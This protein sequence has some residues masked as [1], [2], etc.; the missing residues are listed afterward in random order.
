[1]IILQPTRSLLSSCDQLALE[2]QIAADKSY[3]IDPNNPAG[4]LIN[5]RVGPPATFSRASGATEVDSAGRIVFSNENF[6]LYSNEIILNR[7]WALG[8]TTSTL[9]GTAP[10]GGNAYLITETT[11]NALHNC[12]S[13]GST[14]NIGA[15]TTMLGMIYTGSLFVKKVEGSIDWIQITMGSGGFGTAQYANFNIANGTVGN[16]ANLAP[17]TTPTIEAYG[18][19]WYR[20]SIAAVE[21]ANTTNS[22][23]FSLGF[24]N[25]INGTV[26]LPVYAGNPANRVF[27]AMGQFQ[28]NSFTGPYILTTT[29]PRFAPSFYHDPA[30][31]QSRGLYT[32][33]GRTN[34]VRQ[35]EAF[36][37]TWTRSAI[38]ISSNV[39]I[40]PSG[41]R[42]A[43]RLIE[44]ASTAAHGIAQNIT[45]TATP[46]T[47]SLYAKA[48][49]RNWIRL[50]FGNP[51]PDNVWFNLANGTIGTISTGFSA[52]MQNAGNGWWRCIITRTPTAGLLST[53]MR[54]AS[55][56]GN[57]S[58]PGN[59]SG[60]VYLW[61]AQVEPGPF[62]TRYNPTTNANTIRSVDVCDINGAGFAEMYNPLEG[63]LCVSAIF[64]API[65]YSTSQML[66]DINDTTVSN[67]LRIF[68][69][70]ST[71]Y[72]GFNNTSNSITNVSITTSVAAQP[73]EIQK[74]SV[75]FKQNDYAFYANN[76]LIGTDTD[77]AMPISPTTLT[78]G[79]AA[80]GFSRLYTNGIISSIRY[81]RRRLPNP[82]LL[83][84][85][86]P[87]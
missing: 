61:G 9:S 34:I 49:T 86:Q 65:N 78:I 85:T 33:E 25:N 79:D 23:A 57:I 18:D 28:R 46:H 62:V 74:Y 36:E 75:G 19:G 2:L 30:S 59:G 45:Y 13:Y 42:T 29:S 11:D 32:E 6:A 73:F 71:G 4:F 3:S 16:F 66:V 38:T 15:I 43:D 52:S 26:R 68:R 5:S 72:S 82:K 81:Y 60:D 77:G 55:A 7:G 35:S 63:T 39:E 40:S 31:L 76:T 47:F 12:A 14:T 87:D 44:D 83:A 54:I 48:G 53:Y 84:L 1:M 51:T 69:Q 50:G 37:T 10:L 22:V 8:A 67:R 24:I 56:D 41:D 58:Y 20:V 64:N 17:G 70:N 27:A 80:V 21:T